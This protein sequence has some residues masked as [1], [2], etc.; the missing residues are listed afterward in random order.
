MCGIFGV[1]TKGSSGF[2]EQQIRQAI[3]TLA[4]F[5]ESRGKDTSGV[6]FR[7][8]EKIKIYKGTTTLQHL[9]KYKPVRA[10]FSQLVSF[11]SEG[12][13]VFVMGHSRLVTNG[14][15]NLKD[16]NQPVI[17]NGIVGIHNGI[18]VNDG[19][20]WEAHTDLKR[21]SGVDT[22][23]MMA[24]IDKFI[25]AGQS[26]EM[27]IQ[28]TMGLLF[29]TVSAAVIYKNRDM[30]SL[31][32]N[33]VSLY[34]LTVENA[35]YAFASEDYFLRKM[36]DKIGIDTYSISQIKGGTIYSIDLA[37]VQ[38]VSDLE[39]SRKMEKDYDIEEMVFQKNEAKDELILD[40]AIISRQPSAFKEAGYLECNDEQIASLRRCT[41]CILPETFPFIQ[42]DD[43]GV[44]NYCNNYKIKNA[45][46]SMDKL[47]ELVEPYR[48]SGGE[49]DC[50]VPYSGGRDSTH[51]L[52]IVKNVLN[53]NPLAV[54]Y[55]W[56]MV[57]DLARRNIARV[58]G[59][60][61][62]ENIIVSANIKWKRE[63]IRKNILAWL[64][65]PHLGLI[66]LFMAGDKYFYYYVDKVKK[67]TGI[68]LNIWGINPLEN[69]DFKV[70]FM[71]VPPDHEKERIYSLS[72]KRKM[73]LIS[74]V[75]VNFLRNPAYLNQSVLDTLGSFISR[76][77]VH[78]SDYYHMY[79]FYR[80]DEAE[81][82]DLVLGT[83]D[84][85]KA[86]DTQTTW[87]IGDGT[88]PFYNY[89]YYT[90]AGFSEYD[91]FRSNQ[92]REGMLEREAA[93]ALVRTENRPRYASLKWYTDIVN[94]DFVDVV[95]QI[96]DI[97]KLY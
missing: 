87:R 2:S 41:R 76:S 23:I 44:C 73:K 42:F 94:L 97:P 12:G 93:L 35:F 1:I 38:M 6:V 11:A 91:T 74:G 96:N 20:L 10:S 36:A 82:D 54:T 29:G 83:Y 79:D 34:L 27:A 61:N 77:V 71:G 32:S 40:P 95:K 31:F 16:N 4:K 8:R 5:S 51:T 3:N 22:E 53:L 43:Q 65:A 90:V 62:V 50:I 59:T 66:P 67:Q 64:K 68:R 60:L 39:T 92:I 30:L 56:G 78:H 15:H 25:G 21:G 19:Q 26:V 57:T 14:T 13:S 45:P 52:H 17:K 24:L 84:W 75:G 70:G 81:V 47:H 88:V 85:E 28:E 86:I 18:I 72:F 80:W 89:I 63:N 33:N 9:L 69:T 58:C 55:D 49:Y 37:L 46:K 48:R 7:F